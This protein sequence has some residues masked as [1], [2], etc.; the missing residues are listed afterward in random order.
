MRPDR[1]TRVGRITSSSGSSGR[2]S[3]RCSQRAIR[4]CSTRRTRGGR[5]GVSTCPSCP[6]TG[7]A[8]RH[9]IV[10]DEE[11][12]IPVKATKTLG[13]KFISEFRIEDLSVDTPIARD[14]LT[15]DFPEGRPDVRSDS[16]FRRVALA[17]VAAVV[18]Y[19]PLVPA[20]VP[21]GYE[22]AEVAAARRPLQVFTGED[23]QKIVQMHRTGPEAMNP[24]SR[25]VV[26]LSYRRGLDQFVVTTRA[27]HVPASAPDERGLTPDATGTTHSPP[28]TASATSRSGSRSGTARSQARESSS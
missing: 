8:D 21:P 6:P 27:R 2:S 7:G 12:G 18:G 26:S 25:R 1:R 28:A 19:A 23:G 17:D 10:V 14:Q 24:D 11:T 4:V 15:I 9:E 20:R 16:G 13:G 3:R 22:L 5:R